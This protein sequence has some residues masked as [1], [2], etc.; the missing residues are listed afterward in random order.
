[1]LPV[2]RILFIIFIIALH[3]QK[4]LHRNEYGEEITTKIR[5]QLLSILLV[6]YE[7]L[8]YIFATFLFL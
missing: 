5:F 8:K 4:N 6:V 2:Y 3:T 1:M 7:I